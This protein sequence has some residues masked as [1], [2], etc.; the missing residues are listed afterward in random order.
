LRSPEEIRFRL[1][2]ELGNLLLFVFPPAHPGDAVKAEQSAL[3]AMAGTGHPALP[4][5][6]FR[7]RR[8]NWSGGGNAN[9]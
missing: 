9:N 8:S 5:S 4:Y 2:Q 1:R 7:R 6:R 3:R